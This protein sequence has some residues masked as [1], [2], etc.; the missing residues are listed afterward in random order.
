MGFRLTRLDRTI[1]WHSFLAIFIWLV[2]ASPSFAD[3][4]YTVQTGDSAWSIAIRFGV[5]LEALYEANGWASDEDPVLQIGQRIAIPSETD[6]AA[7]ESPDNADSSQSD[8]T[9]AVQEGD[10]PSIIADK[11]GIGT[12]ELLEYNNLTGEDSIQAGQV[13]RIPPEGYECQ[14]A[15]DTDSGNDASQADSQP[16]AYVVQAGDCLW[17][18]A[19]NFQVGV[20]AIC[21]ANGISRET[22]LSVGSEIVIPSP[23]VTPTESRITAASVYTVV[24]GDTLSGIASRFGISQ[25]SIIEANGLTNANTIRAGIELVIPGFRGSPETQDVDETPPDPSPPTDYSGELEPLPG[26]NSGTTDLFDERSSIFDFTAIAPPEPSNPDAGDRPESGWSVDGTSEDGT[27]Y[28]VYT[29]RRGDTISEVALAFGIS[30]DDLIRWNGLDARTALRIGRDLRVPLPRPADTARPGGT[31]A[32]HT[33]GAPSVPIG[34]GEGSDIGRAIVEEAAKYIGTPYVYA[35]SDL[36][37]GTDCSG[38][39][40]SVMSMFGISL[41]HRA[42]LQAQIGDEVAYSD[43]QPGDLVFFQTHRSS[44]YLGITHVGIYIGNGDFIHASSYRGGVV[45]STMETGSYNR[46]FVCA[47]RLF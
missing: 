27:P 39:A 40:M 35:G 7:E 23:E 41:P 1:V 43:L 44:N 25:V 42:S 6:A 4:I 32:P 47:R 29:I 46:N 16:T 14:G 20:Q 34:V 5:T 12:L 38:F 30:Q 28:H 45:I 26:L 11:L 3:T 17:T 10:C 33:P 36:T 18:I 37:R 22:I 19:R 2:L 21:D 15:Y 8:D 9:Y 13:L 31:S 24:A